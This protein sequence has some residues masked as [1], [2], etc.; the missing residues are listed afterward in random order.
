M[1]LINLRVGLTYV[2]GYF[3]GMTSQV[4]AFWFA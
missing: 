4:E 1:H 3:P 2:D